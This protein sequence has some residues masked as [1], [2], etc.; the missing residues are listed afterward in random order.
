MITRRLNCPLVCLTVLLWAGL[1]CADDIRVMTSGAFTAAYLELCPQFE[2]ATGHHLVTEATSMGTGATSIEARLAAGEAVDVVIVADAALAQ[3]VEKGRILPGT[4]VPLARSQIGMAVRHGAPKPDIHSV[5]AL[6]RTLLAAK[7]IAYSASVSGTYL[8]TELFQQLGIAEQVLPKSRRIE[9]ERVAAVVARGEAEIGFQ[10]I[11]ELLPEPGIDFVGP[12]PAEV[13]RTTVFSAGVAATARHPAAA[14]QF[15]EFLASPAA[16]S[17]IVNSAL[18]PIA[19]ESTNRPTPATQTGSFN[20]IEAT[21][22]DV[23][24]A[25]TSRQITCRAIVEEYIRRIEAYDKSGPALNAVQTINRNAVIQAERLDSVFATSG[26]AGPLHCVPML[27]KDQLETSDMP[28]T[29]G[30]VL[31]KQFVP[32]R[33]A[34]VVTRL[35]AAGAVILG[36][37]TMGEFASG[38]L[39]SAFGIVRNAY[40]P[41]RVASGS[42]GGSGSAVAANFA[43]AAIGED[44]GGSTRGP[45]AVNNLVGLRPT[46]PLVSRFGMLPARPSTDTLGPITRSVRDAAIVLDAI[47]GYDRNDATTAESVG[48]IPAS[49]TRSLAVDGLSGARIGRVRDPLDPKADRE[50]TGYKQV[51]AVIDR[52]VADLTRLGAVVVDFSPIPDVAARS[53]RIYDGNVFETEAA[54][55]K[56]LSQHPNAPVKTLAEI[57]LSGKVV[58]ARARTLMTTIGHSTD[59]AGYLQLIIAKEELRQ[60]V[61]AAMAD[62]QLDALVYATFDYPPMPIPVDALTQ[63]VIDATGPGNNRRLSPALGFPALTVPAG[64][65]ADGLPVGLEF[66]AR[67]FAEATLLRFAYAYEQGTHHRKPP[68]TTPML[69]TGLTAR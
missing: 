64:F 28:T 40:D 38:Y 8:S 66:M 58:P 37:T 34:T 69:T 3:L 57:L 27:V 54:T 43:T 25:L 11:S 4:R 36:K 13:Q 14:R 26:A 15:I 52:A 60:A 20:V 10:Q 18:E 62:Q 7:S 55:N 1:A 51:R 23:H 65:T 41:T 30:S 6:K 16:A 39:G 63:T 2:G 59:E 46:V 33:E 56:Y 24:K 19:G 5:D 31:F 67:P 21:I 17:A 22:D 61:F 48:H 50:S 29:Y 32:T 45:A 35:K 9:R 42:S 47:A 53:A 44:T 68:R 12:L 49:Y